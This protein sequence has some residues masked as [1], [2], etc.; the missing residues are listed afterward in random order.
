MSDRNVRNGLELEAFYGLIKSIDTVKRTFTM[1][2]LGKNITPE[3]SWDKEYS[4]TSGGKGIQME[5]D[6]DV[7]SALAKGL[8]ENVLVMMEKHKCTLN[9]IEST[10]VLV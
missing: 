6:S 9:S 5:Y 1:K 7:L 4:D 8:Q 10:E 3:I 2:L